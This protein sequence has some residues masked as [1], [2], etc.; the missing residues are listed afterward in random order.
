MTFT[1]TDIEQLSKDIT[2]LEKISILQAEVERL[3]G[4]LYGLDECP[5]CGLI[6]EHSFNC[7]INWE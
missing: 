4:L 6:E 7:Q 3:R 5:D 1:E 2:A